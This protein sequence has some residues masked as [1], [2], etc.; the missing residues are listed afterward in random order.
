MVETGLVIAP[1]WCGGLATVIFEVVLIFGIAVADMMAK[2]R[3]AKDKEQAK[4][5]GIGRERG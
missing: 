2:K 4:T 1:F 3:S 5:S